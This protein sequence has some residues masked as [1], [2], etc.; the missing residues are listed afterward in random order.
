MSIDL[1]IFD[2]DGV[3]V[4]SEPLMHSTLIQMVRDFGGSP[5]LIDGLDRFKGAALNRIFAYVEAEVGRKLPE[6]AEQQFRR[7]ISA[8]F[9]AELQPVEG[10]REVLDQIET[11]V[12]VASNGPLTKMR[13]TLELTG[14]LPHFAGRLFSSYE[15]QRWKPAPD[16]Y[17]YAADRM[18][19]EPARCV[20]IE[21][22]VAG[23][24]AAKAAGMTVLGYTAAFPA[25][26]LQEAGAS[27]F[28]H[29]RELPGRLTTLFD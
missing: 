24:L 13:Y 12:C 5:R 2:C 22:S 26:A 10:I 18:G 19:V 6:D 7:L 20:V 3:L 15:I 9:K 8:A 17:L 14:L 29:M 25:A 1:I 28:D 21:D 23:V 11:P 27:V 16:I 4:D